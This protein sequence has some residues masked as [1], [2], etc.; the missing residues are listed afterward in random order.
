MPERQK[1][2][3]WWS[4]DQKWFCILLDDGNA[5][6]TVSLTPEEASLL[7]MNAASPPKFSETSCSQCGRVFGP[8]NSGFSHCDQ[9]PA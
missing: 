6:A 4:A 7:S 5:K 3:Y 8:G 1:I 2:K 9:H